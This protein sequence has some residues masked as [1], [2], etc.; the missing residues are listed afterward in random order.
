MRTAI[1]LFSALMLFAHLGVFAQT[2]SEAADD[3][4]SEIYLAKDDGTGKAGAAATEFFTTDVPIYCVVLLESTEPAEVKMVLVAVSVPGVKPETTVVTTAYKTKEGENRV[5]FSGRPV[6][7]WI[8]GK[9]RADIYLQGKLL[10]KL[11]FDIEKY[12]GTKSAVQGAS[13]IKTNNR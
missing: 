6:G 5:N 9:Y 11:D 4:I 10:F 2:Q 8:A 12:R 3:P 13:R 1:I 7:K